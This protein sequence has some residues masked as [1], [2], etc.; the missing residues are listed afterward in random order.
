MFAFGEM[1]L[2]YSWLKTIVYAQ[3]TC[4]FILYVA[5]RLVSLKCNVELYSVCD[6]ETAL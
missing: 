1:A 2:T 3:M 4:N 6:G 5:C